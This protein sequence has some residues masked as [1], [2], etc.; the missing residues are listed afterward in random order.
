MRARFAGLLLLGLLIA[1]G[2]GADPNS[3]AGGLKS[4][5]TFDAF[6]LYAP[7][8]SFGD[9]ELEQVRRQPGYVE[10][11]YA[12][13]RPLRVEVWPG[14]VRTPFLRQGVLVEGE[15]YERTIV[16]RRATAY[17]FDAGRRLEVPLEGAT[18]VVRAQTRR[19]AREAV[20]ALEGVNNPLTREDPLPGVDPEQTEAGC[21]VLDPE[22]PLIEARLEEAL[23]LQG[24]HL[25]RCGRSLSVA[26]TDGIDD[27]HDCVAGTAGAEPSFWCV[28]SRGKELVAGAMAQSCEAAVLAGAVARPLS[29]TETLGWGARA[30]GLCEPHLARVPEVIASMAG[31]R[32]VYDLSYVWE[33]MGAYEADVVA[34]LRSVSVPSLE[35]E[36]VLA[37]YEA[38]I[39]AIR[40]AVDR[41]HA[42]Q[43]RKALADLRRIEGETAELV[44][45]FQTLGAPQ[46][47][48]PW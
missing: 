22:A 25:L 7:G 26:R 21:T 1:A 23:G 40:A 42:G 37:L 14:C 32:A 3:E 10:F 44:A 45:R 5:E 35:V 29:E 18:V 6:P 38:R 31:E 8:D 30:G 17:A 11:R 47:A 12:A 24:P 39:E 41:Y 15:P 36:A 48:P 16:V 9:A 28:L 19:A 34:E 13:E 20:G 2:C 43:K 4:F 27:A 46:C 33:V